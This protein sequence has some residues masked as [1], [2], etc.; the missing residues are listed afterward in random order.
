MT[1]KHGPSDDNLLQVIAAR[2]K[3]L[4]AKV[5]QAKADARRLL[6]EAQR[7]AESAR[8]SVR[9]EVTELA[10][11][12]QAEAVREAEALASQRLAAAEVEAQR[13]RAR[14]QE[15]IREAVGLVV[16]RVLEGLSQ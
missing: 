1:G 7:Q 12:V 5:A 11:R 13:V 15:R 6:E 10:A 3:E 9:G 4:E 2:E 14:A 8:E 16:Q